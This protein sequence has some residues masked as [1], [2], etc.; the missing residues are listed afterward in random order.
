MNS[1]TSPSELQGLIAEEL[2]LSRG[3][4]Q[5]GVGMAVWEDGLQHARWDLIWSHFSDCV[6]L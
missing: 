5:E 4:D 1:V 2:D 6:P 3:R